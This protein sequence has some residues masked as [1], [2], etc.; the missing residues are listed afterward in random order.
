MKY[1]LREAFAYGVFYAYRLYQWNCPAKEP[2]NKAVAPVE[3]E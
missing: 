1:I 2:L 3:R